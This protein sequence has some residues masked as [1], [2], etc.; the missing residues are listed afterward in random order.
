MNKVIIKSIIRHVLT[1]VATLLAAK[2]ISIDA[3]TITS[4]TD[5]IL[6]LVLGGGVMV[7]SAVEKS[8][9]N[10]VLK[11]NPIIEPEPVVEVKQWFL[12]SRSKGN[13]K[14]LHKD[15]V[16]LINLALVESPYDFVV[17]SGERTTKEQRALVDAKKSRT[18]NSK[19]IKQ[20]DGYVHAFDF[21]AL[22]AN[23][24]GTWEYNYYRD[25]VSAMKR[26][27][28]RENLD[29]TFG[30]DWVGFLDSGHVQIGT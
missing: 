1:V 21:M 9:S 29:I 11:E 19:H 15:L 5:L 27:V 23:G 4:I 3:G 20:S 18:M 16:E 14:G 8:K 13:M 25:I 2:G 6:G 24:V 30:H 28:A 12:S 17:I 7:Q 10:K 22:D 26:I